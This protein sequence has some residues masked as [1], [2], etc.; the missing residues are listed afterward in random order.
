[1]II[2]KVFLQFLK[3]L[4]H[5]GQKM[6]DFGTEDAKYNGELKVEN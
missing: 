6:Q 4:Y 2:L 1:M 3:K 5:S